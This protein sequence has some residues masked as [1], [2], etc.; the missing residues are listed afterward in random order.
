MFAKSF[1]TFDNSCYTHLLLSR[2]SDN[3]RACFVL[4][5]HLGNSLYA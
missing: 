5:S 1:K 3:E 4:I 2:G